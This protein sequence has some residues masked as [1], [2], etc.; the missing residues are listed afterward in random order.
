ML[1]GIRFQ[2]CRQNPQRYLSQTVERYE[3]RGGQFSAREWGHG[4]LAGS[5]LRP[6]VDSA[7]DWPSILTYKAKLM[8]GGEAA[9]SRQTV[10]GPGEKKEVPAVVGARTGTLARTTG[11]PVPS[12]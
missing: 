4:F 5:H 3:K 2:R 10:V 6:G 9:V 12:Q 1:G 7:S 11:V 8:R